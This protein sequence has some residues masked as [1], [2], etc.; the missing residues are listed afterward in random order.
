MNSKQK[1]ILLLQNRK[2]PTCKKKWQ[3][4]AGKNM[5]KLASL[6]HDQSKFVD[7]SGTWKE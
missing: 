2:S 1:K 7:M 3:W 4:M 6:F 5:D